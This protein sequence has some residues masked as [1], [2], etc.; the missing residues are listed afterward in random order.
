MWRRARWEHPRL[1]AGV[2]LSRSKESSEDTAPRPALV[3]RSSRAPAAGGGAH[4]MCCRRGAHREL[5][6]PIAPACPPLCPAHLNKWI[7]CWSHSAHSAAHSSRP[8]CAPDGLCGELT[9]TSRV[10]PGRM[11]RSTSATANRGA[12]LP[13]GALQQGKGRATVQR[14]CKPP[15]GRSVCSEQ[16]AAPSKPTG[17]GRCALRCPA[18]TGG[19]R[20]RPAG[21]RTWQSASAT[22]R[23]QWTGRTRRATGTPGMCTLRGPPATATPAGQDGGAR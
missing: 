2:A 6:P 9:T 10:L 17:G 22:P 8:K 15:A 16:P 7:P 19:Q 11:R 1:A 5:A 14:K 13:S 4:C 18:S 12:A 21:T 3:Q 23:S 20:P